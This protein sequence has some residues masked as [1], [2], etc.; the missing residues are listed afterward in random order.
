MGDNTAFLCTDV[1]VVGAGLAGCEAALAAAGAGARVAL[2]CAG[3]IFGGSSFYGGTWGLG[4]VGPRDA[5][6]AAAEDLAEAVCSVGRGCTVP[7]LV[8]RLVGGVDGAVLRLRARGVELAV[9]AEPDQPAYIPCFDTELRGWH[10]L[11]RASYRSA[12]AAALER[13]GVAELARHDLVDLLVVDGTVTGAVLFDRAAGAFCTVRAGA[14]VLATGGF[15]GLYGRTLTMPDVLGGASAVALAHG[16][17]L[18]NAEFIQI[19]PGFVDPAGVVFNEKT[20]G[21]ARLD[22]VDRALMAARAEH[23]PFTA[24]RPDR[25]VDLAMVGA[26]PGGAEVRFEAPKV[27][28]EFVA[29][30]NAWFE[31]A[32]GRSAFAPARICAYAHASNGG[33]LVDAQGATDVAGLFAAGEAT[34]GMHGADRIGGLASANAL[35]FGW[36]AGR[37]AAACALGREDGAAYSSAAA[38]MADGLAFGPT[39]INAP[40]VIAAV[41][42]LM[43]RHCLVVRS[44]G[45]LAAAD[46]TLRELEG[47]LA[48][49]AAGTGTGL[50]A[51]ATARTIRARHAVV[52]AR[53]LVA[54]MRERRESRGAHYRS[55]FV[56]EDPSQARPNTVALV[57]GE[58]QIRPYFSTEG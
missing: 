13:A 16:A 32:F 56:A 44:E 42:E 55:D 28:P 26:G 41:K 22:G 37:S 30:Y 11:G 48:D 17:R 21:M 20:F 52:A 58:P 39:S 5:T 2:A 53:S 24:S 27:V 14:V 29:T 8:R 31:G 10:G 18:V 50:D 15:G 6:D 57:D 19:M 7:A 46:D 43:D 49:G 35:V 33:L 23:G 34:G 9:P 4:L 3:S 36:E 47:F 25:A 45:G 38:D 51:A 1:L 54:A 40:Q 12:T